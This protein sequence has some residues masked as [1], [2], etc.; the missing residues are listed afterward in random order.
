MRKVEQQ[1]FSSS[2]PYP[3]RINPYTSTAPLPSS[4]PY[5]NSSLPPPRRLNSAPSSSPQKKPK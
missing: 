2:A 5:S 1:V 4:A 3:N